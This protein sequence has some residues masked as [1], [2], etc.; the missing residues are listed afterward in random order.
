M[1]AETLDASSG[2]VTITLTLDELRILNNALNET[3]EVFAGSD[4]ELSTRVGAS[5]DE[6]QELLRQ[7]HALVRSAGS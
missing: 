4:S 3:L 6:V 1:K 2:Y 5:R 7:I